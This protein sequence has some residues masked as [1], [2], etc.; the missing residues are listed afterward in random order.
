MEFFVMAKMLF[1]E[2]IFALVKRK[3]TCK[4]ITNDLNS[5]KQ[6]FESLF[7]YNVNIQRK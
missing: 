5:V 2:S 7:M 6:C 4:C 3:L 1:R